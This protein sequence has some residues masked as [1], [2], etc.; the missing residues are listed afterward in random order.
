MKECDMTGQRVDTLYYKRAS[1]GVAVGHRA[2]GDL[3]P[4]DLV[5]GSALED[6]PH[7]EEVGP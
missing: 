6:A 1:N 5:T 7:V 2:D 3:Y 4:A